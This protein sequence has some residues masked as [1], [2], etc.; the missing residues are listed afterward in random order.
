[1]YLFTSYL[2]VVHRALFSFACIVHVHVYNC[3]HDHSYLQSLSY[4][5]SLFL[6]YPLVIHFLVLPHSLIH[7]YTS[8]P[9]MYLYIHFVVCI[10]HFFYVQYVCRNY[11]TYVLF[12]TEQTSAVST[13][14]N[15]ETGK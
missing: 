13:S 1:M 4:T 3:V 12:S 2:H 10:I 5:I 11:N 14:V 8:H 9:Y 7:R 6:L 15:D